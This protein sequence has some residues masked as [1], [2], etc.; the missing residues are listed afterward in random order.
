MCSYMVPGTVQGR[1]AGDKFA[2]VATVPYDAGLGSRGGTARRSACA[3]KETDRAGR[4][5][6][7]RALQAPTDCSWALQGSQCLL[8][9]FYRLL[10]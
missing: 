1:W 9:P 6:K 8:T 4:G 7:R 10:G 2:P 5:P 3:V